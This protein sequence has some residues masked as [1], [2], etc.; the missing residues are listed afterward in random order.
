MR[1]SVIVSTYNQPDWLEKVVWGYVAQSEQNF[2]LVVADDGSG[3]ETRQLIQ[4][5]RRETGLNLRHVWHEDHGFRKC[6]ILNR[7]IVEST[8]DYLVFSDGDCIPRHDFLAAH[9]RHAKAGHYLSGGYFKLPLAIS[10]RI[11]RD[12]IYLHRATS[13]V[14][15]RDRG[16]PLS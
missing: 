15:L 14:W 9:V 2:E 7:A 13:A 3:A 6:T 1:L 16:L 5:L 10:K 11:T 8:G 4:R 12:D